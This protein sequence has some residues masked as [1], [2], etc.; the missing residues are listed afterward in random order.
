MKIGQRMEKDA[1]IREEMVKDKDNVD[2]NG[3]KPI[4]QYVM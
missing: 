2:R 1:K 4:L 3:L